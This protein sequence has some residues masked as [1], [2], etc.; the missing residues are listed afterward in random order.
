MQR[1]GGAHALPP[2]SARARPRTL[3]P[4]TPGSRTWAHAS[5]GRCNGEDARHTAPAPAGTARDISFSSS[6]MCQARRS[7]QELGHL[8]TRPDMC[9][10]ARPPTQN[11]A[12]GRM[13]SGRS[14]SWKRST[15]VLGGEQFK[16]THPASP[17]RPD[18]CSPR[19]DAH[20][21]AG[22]SGSSH[23]GYSR[24]CRKRRA[25]PALPQAEVATSSMTDCRLRLGHQPRALPPLA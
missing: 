16:R 6:R 1:A 14:R 22:A 3:V 23:A 13:S 11:G 17:G 4:S 25:W 15:T 10:C 21:G 20:V 9:A 18:P 7:L 19:N 8:R 24:S 12:Q 2:W 5:A